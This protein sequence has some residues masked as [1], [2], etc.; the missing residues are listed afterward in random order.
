MKIVKNPRIVIAGSVNSSF[1][2]LKKLIEHNC[3]LVAVLGLN[4]NS[5]KNVSGYLDSKKYSEENG[6]PF[7]Y[8]SKINDEEIYSFIKE[9]QVDLFF[10]IGLSQLIREPL[11]SVAKYGNVGFHPTKLPE[12]RGRGAIAWMVL[13]KAKGAATFFYLDEGMDSGPILGQSEYE[14]MNDDYAS[15]VIE[16]V[17][18]HID[19]VLDEILPKLKKGNLN[20]KIQ[21]HTL[22]T[23]LGQ[24]K[25]KD[26]LIDWSKSVEEVHRLIRATSKP[27]PGAFTL[28]NEKKL[29]IYRSEIE[30]KIDYIGIP[31]RVIELKD[32]KPLVACGNGSLW[33]NNYFFEEEIKFKIGLDL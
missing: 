12:G 11:L 16:R 3:N 20:L 24:R 15:D 9:L 32:N 14:I 19:I 4:P 8:F 25:P 26:G 22:A 28:I 18:L 1:Q 30:K 29:I 13:G 17:K 7:K 10:I 23:F 27:L 2:T 31:G 5:S 21:D 33:L 6:I